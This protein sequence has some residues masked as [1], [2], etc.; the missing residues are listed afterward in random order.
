MNDFKLA[1]KNFNDD[2]DGIEAL[3]VI[4]IVAVAAICLFVV[5]KI[6][7]WGV[8]QAG[9]NVKEAGDELKKASQAGKNVQLP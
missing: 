8:G 5:Y 2:E 6:V 3:Q 9:D 4:L 1:I 7:T